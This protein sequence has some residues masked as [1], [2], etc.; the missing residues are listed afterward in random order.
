VVVWERFELFELRER[1]AT[2]RHAPD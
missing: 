2:Q 1:L